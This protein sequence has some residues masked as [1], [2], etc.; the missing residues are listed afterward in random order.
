[1]ADTIDASSQSCSVFLQSPEALKEHISPKLALLYSARPTA[2]NL[3]AAMTRLTKVL[4]DGVALQL[5]AIDVAHAL[6][7]EGKLIADEDVGRNKKMS[8]LGAEWLL[9][10]GNQGGEGLNVMTVCNTGSLA[11]SGE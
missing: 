6:V 3:G 8:Q 2:V 4:E 5:P 11:T 1:M 7:D 10:Q 9:G